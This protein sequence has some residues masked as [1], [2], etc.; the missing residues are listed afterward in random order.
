MITHIK[1]KL[2]EKNPSFV[3]IDC[4]GVGYLLRISLQTYSKLSNDEFC[5]LFTHLSIK[6]DAHTLY[7]FFDKEERELF[8]QLISVSGVGPNTAQMI[9][10]SL[11]PHEIQQA[12][13]TENVKV[14]QGVKGI[15]GK[16][17]QR[18]I[19]D[20]KDKIAK[21]GISANSSTA[22]YNTIR[23]EALSALTM[24]GFSKNSIEKSI[25]KELQ[26]GVNLEV[27]ELVKRVLKKM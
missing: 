9:L 3:I 26:D 21:L 8:R 7:G 23:E 27:E 24:L 4:N 22:S 10:S 5:M 15:G 11:T 14:L 16:T 18:I 2:I 1:G 20:L 6:E 17:A 19:L 13:L 25:D 12:I